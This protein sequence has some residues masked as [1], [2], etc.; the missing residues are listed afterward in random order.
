MDEQQEPTAEAQD[1]P[2]DADPMHDTVVVVKE[3]RSVGA[4]WLLA[5]GLALIA[6]PVLIGFIFLTGDDDSTSTDGSGSTSADGG[7][8]GGGDMTGSGGGDIGGG[9][10]IGVG[11]FSE[12]QVGSITIT[13]DG[14][15]SGAVLTVGTSIEAA[16]AVAYGPTQALGSIATDSDMQ[17]GGHT[18][19]SPVM[20]GLEPGTT[21]SYRLSGIGPDGRLYQSELMT[22]TFT[23]GE[24]STAPP[25][26]EIPA[27]NVASLATVVDVSSEFSPNFAGSNAI[28]GDLATEWSSAGDGD[29]AY[30]V[31]DF[32]ED[33]LA[34]GVGFRTREMSDGTSITTSF[35][36][37][38]DGRM[39]GPFEAGPGL[40]VALVNLEGQVFRFDVATS[41]GGNTGAVEVEVYGEPAM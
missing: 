3:E 35:T 4:G 40:A 19:H 30:V 38:V 5:A 22:F 7:G 24:S 34:R 29:D 26:V 17:G 9:L 6:I 2:T 8:M 13:P 37:T 12:I 31:L 21:Y 18:D 14:S 41:T 10:P 27:P 15:G 20:T 28:D 16:C 32:G 33:I 23:P 25:A 36:V 11:N 1:E 39:F